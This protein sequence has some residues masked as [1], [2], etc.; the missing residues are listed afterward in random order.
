MA[1]MPFTNKISMESSKVMELS[2]AAASFEDGYMQAR[3]SGL[4]S[5]R[6]VWTITW[7]ALTKDELLSLSNTITTNRTSTVYYY[8]PCYEPDIKKYRLKK[9]SWSMTP[10]GNDNFS[11]SATFVQIFDLD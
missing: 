2:A 8:K 6:E 5:V 11:A 3:P 9:D 1:N 4:N 7:V 10:K